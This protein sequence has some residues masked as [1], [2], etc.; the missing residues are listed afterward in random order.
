MIVLVSLLEE[1]G[2]LV[3]YLDIMLIL[4]LLQANLR[5]VENQVNTVKVYNI[6]QSMKLG[7]V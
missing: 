7:Q 6:Y 3:S 5:K 1:L 2:L 4:V